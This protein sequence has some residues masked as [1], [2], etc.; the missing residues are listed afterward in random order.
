MPE[1][2][3]TWMPADPVF[4]KGIDRYLRPADVEE[5]RLMSGRAPEPV[6]RECIE[7]SDKAW[8]AFINGEFAAIAGIGSGTTLGGGGRPWMMG[9]EVLEKHP[10]LFVRRSKLLVEEMAQEYG[11][12]YNL[13]WDGHTAAKKW[14]QAVGFTLEEPKPYGVF[15]APF[16]YFWRKPLV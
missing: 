3:V 14:L 13:V 7:L 11:K 4:A 16:R 1:A 8:V 2:S 6:V 10:L 5:L 9:S 12:L 15:G